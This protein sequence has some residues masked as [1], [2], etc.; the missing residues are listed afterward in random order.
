MHIIKN[1]GFF[2][3]LS[4]VLI[5]G[6]FALIALFGFRYGI[7]FTG[8]SLLEIGFKEGERPTQEEMVER[9]DT[10]GWAGTQAQAT[11]ADGYIVRTT[12]SPNED[13]RQELIAA[14]TEGGAIQVEERRFDSIGPT[15]GAELR[16]KAWA[17]IALVIICIVLYIAFAF[18]HVS[19]PIS[20]WVYG[21]VAIVA[22][23]H[24]VII[25][26]GVYALLSH[27]ILEVQIDVLF[28]IAILTVLGFSVHDTIVV[29]DRTRE[30]LRLRTWKEFATTVGHSVDQTIARSINTSLT[31]LLVVLALYFVGPDSTKYFALTLGVGIIAGT[32]SSIFIASPLLVTIEAW[33]RKRAEAKK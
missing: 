2:Y 15:I 18:R 8:G 30:N 27:Y 28:V 6:S 19:H 13:E 21:G 25:P 5:V 9:L 23:A 12:K 26:A 31:T 24:D 7:E 32:Y 33:Q 1:R 17:A 4:A 22:L 14:I 11:G 20:S 3:L 29:F 10:L 16:G